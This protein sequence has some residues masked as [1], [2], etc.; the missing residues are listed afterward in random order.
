MPNSAGQA[1]MIVTPPVLDIV[2][3]HVSA[4]YRYIAA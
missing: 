3:E 1:E 2:G 4:N